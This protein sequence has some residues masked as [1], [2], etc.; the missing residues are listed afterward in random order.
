MI[1]GAH[2]FA[3]KSKNTFSE[4]S[5]TIPDII[6]SNVDRRTGEP[7]GH[8]ERTTFEPFEKFGDPLSRAYEPG[9]AKW[10]PLD[11]PPEEFSNE[12]PIRGSRFRSVDSARIQGTKDPLVD[13]LAD[14]IGL[15]V[16]AALDSIKG[17]G[18]TAIADL[19]AKFG[20]DALGTYLPY[21]NF[22]LSQRTPWGIYLFLEQLLFWSVRLADQAVALRIRLSNTDAAALAFYSV[23]RHELFHFHV[24]RFA[25]REE[26]IQRKPIYLPYVHNVFSQIPPG[27][28][29]LEECLAQACVIESSLVDLRVECRR[30]PMRKL[31]RHE[32]RTFGPGYRDFECIKYGDAQPAHKILGAQIATGRATPAFSVTEFATPKRLYSEPS[33]SVPGYLLYNQSFVTRFQ[34]AMPKARKWKAFADANGIAF[35]G[36]G[37]TKFGLLASK[38]SRST[39]AATSLIGLRSRLSANFWIRRYR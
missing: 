12:G 9:L 27:E 15:D 8:P 34:L 26:V 33:T 2:R 13:V 36:P 7:S 29:W 31:L 38:N 5:R 1:S 11:E 18:T 25:V 19:T 17:V 22:G 30:G 28:D 21:H 20:T 3:M 10:D 23:F 6:H 35:V 24:E 39:I 16:S 14:E 37:L 32:F 4:E